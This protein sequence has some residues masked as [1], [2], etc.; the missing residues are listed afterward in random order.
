MQ[1]N[2]NK[3]LQRFSKN[4]AI[5]G[6]F[7]PIIHKNNVNYLITYLNA[8]IHAINKAVRKYKFFED[9]I[10]KTSETIPAFISFKIG[11]LLRC[12]CESKEM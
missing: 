9:K 10:T 4:D 7:C 11:D 3:Y 8:L 6:Q 5:V 1:T 12:K 2:V